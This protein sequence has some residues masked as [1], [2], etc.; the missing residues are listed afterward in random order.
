NVPGTPDTDTTHATG[1]A[2]LDKCTNCWVENLTADNFAT[3][4]L[5]IGADVKASTIDHVTIQ[6]TSQAASNIADAPSGIG[7]TMGTMVLLENITLTNAYH[8]ISAGGNVAGPNVYT[9]VT[10]TDPLEGA[11]GLPH[12]RDETGPHQ[13]WSTGGLFDNLSNTDWVNIRNAGN[14]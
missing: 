9:N 5:N 7:G 3:N 4:I 6:N 10:I 13:R 11:L 14:E 1:I 12:S 2:N 8:A